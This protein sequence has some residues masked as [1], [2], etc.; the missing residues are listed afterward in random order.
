MKIRRHGDPKVD[1][2]DAEQMLQV[3][4]CYLIRLPALS[5]VL[6]QIKKCINYSCPLKLPPPCNAANIISSLSIPYQTS[7]LS[8]L[9]LKWLVCNITCKL[10][11]NNLYTIMILLQIV[12]QLIKLILVCT[13]LKDIEYCST[14]FCLR[15]CVSVTYFQCCVLDLLS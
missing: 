13:Y 10:K 4:R 12:H 15:D 14:I 8:R 9:L 1:N 11:E 6:V 5:R 3:R 2:K 7:Q